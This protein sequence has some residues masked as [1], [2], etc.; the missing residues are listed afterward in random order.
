M[1]VCVDLCG[2]NIYTCVFVRGGIYICGACD[3]YCGPSAHVWGVCLLSYSLL[4]PGF[5][6]LF[7]SDALQ[8]L[9]AGDEGD[10]PTLFH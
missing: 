1:G 10:V 7:E 9:G 8:V 5:L 3:R 4:S 6:L 2:V